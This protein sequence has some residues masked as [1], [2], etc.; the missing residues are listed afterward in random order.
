MPEPNRIPPCPDVPKVRTSVR[1]TREYKIQLVTGLRFKAHQKRITVGNEHDYPSG[2][3]DPL[4]DQ[5]RS[6]DAAGNHFARAAG[7]DFVILFIRNEGR[8]L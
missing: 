3:P 7:K 8:E 2:K 4:S 1:E 5:V 6:A